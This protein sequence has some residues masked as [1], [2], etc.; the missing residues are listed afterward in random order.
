MISFFLWFFGVIPEL[1]VHLVLLAGVAGLI[2]SYFMPEY[3]PRKTLVKIVSTILFVVGVYFE[4]GLSVKK[5][6]KQKEREWAAKVNT[7]EKKSQKVITEV[8]EIYLD[9]IKVVKEVQVVVQEKIRDIAV[10][11]DSKCQI[12]SET[13]DIHN[14]AARNE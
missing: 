4:G 12:T 11:I 13:V 5:E 9:K 14:Q 2:L 10:N 3:D 8:K 7:A 6:Y 1:L